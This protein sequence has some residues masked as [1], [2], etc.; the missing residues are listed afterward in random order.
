MWRRPRNLLTDSAAGL[1]QLQRAIF[2]NTRSIFLLQNMSVDSEAVKQV[3]GREVTVTMKNN[4]LTAVSI[5]GISISA[6]SQKMQRCTWGKK[7]PGICLLLAFFF[8]KHALRLQP[9]MERTISP[10]LDLTHTS[11]FYGLTALQSLTSNYKD[12]FN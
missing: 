5:S 8:P 2:L 6:D 4:G 3:K 11:Y 10:T 7:S 9:E 1:K 12:H